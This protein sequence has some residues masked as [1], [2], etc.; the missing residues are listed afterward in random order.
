MKLIPKKQTAWGKLEYNGPTYMD[1]QE[2]MKKE[3]PE[4]YNRLQVEVARSKQPNS[5]MVRYTNAN[6]NMKTA[7]TNI[8]MSGADPIGQLYVEA[9]AGKGIPLIFKG[10][11]RAT[12]WGLAKAGNNWAR[13]KIL[14][15]EI[16]NLIPKPSIKH[17]PS[18]YWTNNTPKE[19]A[20]NYK[21]AE[22]I[23][24]ASQRLQNIYNS[25]EYYEN[26]QRAYQKT[27][28]KRFINSYIPN[29][30]SENLKMGVEITPDKNFSYYGETFFDKVNRRPIIS[31][32]KGLSQKDLVE[33]ALHEVAHASLKGGN[34]S[35]VWI[36][37][38][39]PYLESVIQLR[40]PIELAKNFRLNDFDFEG[41]RDLMNFKNYATDINE[42]R[43]R[44]FSLIDQSKRSKMKFNDFI[45]KHSYTNIPSYSY[46]KPDA[47]QEL[48]DLL[49][50]MTPDEIKRLSKYILGVSLIPRNK[51]QPTQ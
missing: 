42:V 27:N 12:Q 33:T 40:K 43:S 24:N 8:G 7:S 19:D 36:Q 5:E 16:N 41:L 10:L 6:G 2:K 38:I 3:D 51:K 18:I 23:N 13:A 48:D 26:L 37:D 35:K 1:V 17:N 44:M 11:G 15:K 22:A 50:I 28:N 30:L 9:A 49:K 14:S 46:G 4:A 25:P 21:T 32:R 47:P 20:I 34:A 45:D 39:Q 29:T 31:L